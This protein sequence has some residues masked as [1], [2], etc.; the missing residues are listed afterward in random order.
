MKSRA[1]NAEDSWHGKRR[2]SDDMGQEGITT[3]LAYI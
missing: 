1:I 2:N 3:L